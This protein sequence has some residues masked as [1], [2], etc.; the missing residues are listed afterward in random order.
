MKNIILSL[1]LGIILF[2]FGMIGSMHL[3]S[4]GLIVI[5]MSI[6]ALEI[7]LKIDEKK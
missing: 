1:V 3:C 4:T 5:F 2:L 6:L 7:Y